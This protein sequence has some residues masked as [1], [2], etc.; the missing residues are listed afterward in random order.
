[1]SKRHKQR[2]RVR[3]ELAMRAVRERRRAGATAMDVGR[4]VTSRWS[5]DMR[6]EDVEVV[7]LAMAVRLVRD[8]LV[9]MTRDNRFMLPE[10]AGKAVP[11]AVR[12]E[13]APPPGFMRVPPR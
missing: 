2:M 9:V 1:M 10:H 8:G 13:D 11:P 3:A 7:G 6:P 4:A 12:V 5:R